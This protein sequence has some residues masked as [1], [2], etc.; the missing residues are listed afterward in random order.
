MSRLDF[1]VRKYWYEKY[2]VELSLGC[3]CN[4][5]LSL[6]CFSKDGSQHVA[7]TYHSFVEDICKKEWGGGRSSPSFTRF[8]HSSPLLTPCP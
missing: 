1:W 2:R 4:F 5:Q 6:W 3:P 7:H 8:F